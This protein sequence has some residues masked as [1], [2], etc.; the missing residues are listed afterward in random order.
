MNVLVVYE[1]L[2]GNTEQIARAV[3]EGCDRGGTVHVVDSDSAPTS[4]EGFDLVVVGGP[5][6]AFSLTRPATRADAVQS[7]SAP[8]APDRGI[9][10]WLDQLDALSSPVPAAVFDTRVD[11]PRLP[12][13]AAKVAR[14]ELRSLGFDTTSKPET[15][16]VRGYAG[17]LLDG[18]VE[19][20]K[21]WGREMAAA[22]SGSADSGLKA[23]P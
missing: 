19:R 8:H 20:A 23:S 17:P 15:F 13:S 9:R 1:S 5:T 4:I 22:A 3:A 18:E 6:H 12:G 10:E 2:W 14:R 16:R 21:R 11:K 7:H